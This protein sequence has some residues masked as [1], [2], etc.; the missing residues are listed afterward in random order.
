MSSPSGERIEISAEIP[1]ATDALAVWI[2]YGRELEADLQRYYH[3]N[4][5]DWLHGDMSSRRLL[6]L[7]DGLP[8]ESLFKTWA[9]RG[10]DWSSAEYREARM[11]NEVALS[12]ADGKGYM[13]TLIK[14]PW[15]IADDEATDDFRRRKHDENLQQ[16]RGKEQ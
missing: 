8:E 10:G 14:S 15:Q 5:A 12:R 13:P 7:I 4:I 11:I 3:V 2:W 1:K 16:L 6:T 9:L